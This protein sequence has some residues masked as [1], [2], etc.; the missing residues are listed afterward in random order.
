MEIGLGSVVLSTAGRDKGRFFIVV[1]I[2]D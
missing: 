1:E 2:V